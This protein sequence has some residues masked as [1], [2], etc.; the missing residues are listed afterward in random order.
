MFV[1]ADDGLP[2]P[3][4]GSGMKWL[5][6]GRAGR[7]VV[8]LLDGDLVRV[9]DGDPIAGTARDTGETVDRSSIALLPPVEPRQV[10]ALW[11]N[12]RAA[13]ERNGWSTPADPLVFA[14]SVGCVIG[15]DASIP[16][17][18][19]EV[20]RVAYEGELAIVI[21]RRTHRVSV[22]DAPAHVFGYTCAN[23]VTAL[24]LLSR[25]PS[26]TQWTRAKSF[27][28]F[29]PL[30]PVIE[31]EFDW[32]SASVRTVVAGRER[33]HFPLADMFFTPPEIVSRLSMEMTLEA[34]DVIL[35][36]TS[37]GVLPMKPGSRV[38]VTIDGIGTLGNTFG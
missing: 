27:D 8:G 13:A 23:D 18:A 14:K 25:D 9:H 2:D 29:G 34:G 6:F 16:A 36:G 38:E 15:P 17:P 7:A 32:A 35:C 31:T 37:V 11:N 28:G 12:F 4:R 30:G 1:L 20:G 24:E 5:R 26:F 3:G 33:Q 21:G 10:L 19:P 22:A